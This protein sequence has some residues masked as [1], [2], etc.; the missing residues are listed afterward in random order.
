MSA[1]AVQRKL[2]HTG[3]SGTAYRGTGLDCAYERSCRQ[4]C[5]RGGATSEAACGVACRRRG[6]ARCRRRNRRVAGS[7][8]RRAGPEFAPAGRGAA[9]PAASSAALTACPHRIRAVTATSFAPVLSKIAKRLAGG[10]SCVDVEITIAD[11]QRAASVAAA[12]NA[13]VWIPDDAS[14]RNLPN[15]VRFAPGADTIATSPLHFVTDPATAAAH[16]REVAHLGWTRHQA[17]RRRARRGW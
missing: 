4:A 15:P 16:A 10:R 2:F 11:G 17:R 7:W 12:T 1:R 14:W 5:A 6:G 3:E 13:D 9:P 8:Q